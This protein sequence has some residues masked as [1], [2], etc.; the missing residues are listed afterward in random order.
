MR[1][2]EMILFI[3]FNNNLKQLSPKKQIPHLEM[4][5]SAYARSRNVL[6]NFNN[7]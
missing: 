5:V 4:V 2:D 6:F 3:K 1:A 7:N